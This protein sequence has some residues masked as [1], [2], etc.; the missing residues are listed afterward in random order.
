[1]LVSSSLSVLGLSLMAVL[2]CGSTTCFRFVREG[3]LDLEGR[4]AVE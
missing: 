2:D 3:T 1:V 4:T